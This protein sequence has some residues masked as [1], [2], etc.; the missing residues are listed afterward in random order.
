MMLQPQL[1]RSADVEMYHDSYDQ[2]DSIEVLYH[3]HQC[4]S[5]CH[6]TNDGPSV[7]APPAQKLFAYK[8]GIHADFWLTM[9]RYIY[10]DK[11]SKQINIVF[12]RFKSMN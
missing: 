11:L 5:Y 2:P 10:N 9:D 8:L 6:Q 7:E 4:L 12:N 3:R 1:H